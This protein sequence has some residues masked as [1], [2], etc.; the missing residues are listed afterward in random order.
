MRKNVAEP[1]VHVKPISLTASVLIFGAAGLLFLFVERFLVPF[2]AEQGL[3]PAINFLVLG[4][5]HVLFFAAALI[6]YRREAHDWSWDHFC[7]RFRLHA[8][9]GK[10]IFLALLYAA[11][12]IGSYVAVFTL[13]KPLVQWVHDLFPPPAVIDEIMGKRP[14]FVGFE[15]SGNW[16]LL[17]LFFIRYFFNVMGEEL[18]WR[19]YLFPRQELTHGKHTWVVHGFLWTAFHLFAPYNALMVLPGALFMSYIVQ[20]YRNTSFFIVDHA[21][22]NAIPGIGIVAGIMG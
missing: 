17:G 13:G 6:A 11:I 15:L 8:I 21:L 5:P 9:K 20:R 4:S 7:K 2:F 16:W 12:S 22:M 14:M 3:P 19:G 1:E 10:T 18:L